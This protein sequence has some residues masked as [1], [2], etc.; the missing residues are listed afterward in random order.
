MV[1]E[2]YP[3]DQYGRNHT[4]WWAPTLMLLGNMV[5]SVGF[6]HVNIWKLAENPTNLSLCRGFAQ[7][8]KHGGPGDVA[9][10]QIAASGP[11]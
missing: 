4:N 2:F 7:G 3:G 9:T 8:W 1:M 10:G 11:R 6:R 5:G